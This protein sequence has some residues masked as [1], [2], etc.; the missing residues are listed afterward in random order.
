MRR[1]TRTLSPGTWNPETAV[2]QVVLRQVD[3]HRRRIR[4]RGEQGTDLLLDLPRTTL[5]REG[6]GLVLEDGA[7][8][9]VR[10]APEP[11]IE[12]SGPPSELLRAAWHIGNRH[13]PAEMRGDC[14]RLRA[15][16]VIA[17]MLSGLG[18]SPRA[19]DAPFN[20][21]PGAYAGLVGHSHDH[22]HGHSHSHDHRRDHGH[23]HE[24]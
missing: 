5:L 6:E 4:L 14:I 23:T 18:L 13:L 22:D 3:R 15:D 24:S 10:A 2:D 1:A 21:E 12:I 7:T 19:L 17:D 9:L 11:L 16:H 20:P 8:V